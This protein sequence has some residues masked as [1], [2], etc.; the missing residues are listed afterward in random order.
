MV[1]VE[2]PVQKDASIRVA[3]VF[4]G[5]HGWMPGS[6][7]PKMSDGRLVIV[8]GMETEGIDP[9][10]ETRSRHGCHH[11]PGKHI[12]RWAEGTVGEVETS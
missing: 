7:E 8:S 10:N 1:V 9:G 4:A 5:V 11:I 6:T 3:G 12:Y 2:N